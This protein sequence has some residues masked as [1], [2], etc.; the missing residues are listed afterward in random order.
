[1][2]KIIITGGGSG[3]HTM[4]AIATIEILKDYFAQ[5]NIEYDF[6]YVGSHN[7]IEK[8]IAAKNAINFTPISTGKLRRYISYKNL[9]DIFKVF[10]GIL[11]SFKVIFHY[12]PDL[13]FSTGGF[14]SVPVVIAGWFQKVKIIVHEQTIDAGLANKIAGKFADTIALTF[15]ESKKYFPKDKTVVTGIPLRDKIFQG[16]KTQAFTKFGLTESL[17]VL[18]VSGGGLGCHSI[19]TSFNNIVLTLLEKTNVII[20]TGN[21]NDGKDYLDFLRLRENIEDEVLKKRLLIFNFIND[22]IADIYAIADLSVARSGAGTVN[23]FIAL[24]IPAIFVPLAIA[25]NDEQYKNAV[26]MENMQTALIIKEKDLSDT[27]LL[28]TISDI[29]FTEKLVVMKNHFQNTQS[30]Y[31]NKKI[32]DCIIQLLNSGA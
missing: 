31:G 7:G 26:I 14:V 5:K 9:I 11:D 4:P 24:K 22:E 27:L 15:E 8:T 18:Y 23:E 32:L 13:I 28:K 25:T 19:N 10:K 3:G 6:L 29:L 17:P 16:D 21:A 20:Q 1:M 2:I 30:F 12:K